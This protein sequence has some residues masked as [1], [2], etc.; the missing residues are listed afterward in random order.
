[1]S[2]FHFGRGGVI[3]ET[4][5]R[6]SG[7]DLLGVTTLTLFPVDCVYVCWVLKQVMPF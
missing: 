5:P 2:G 6:P 7:C 3:R 4:E 1:M